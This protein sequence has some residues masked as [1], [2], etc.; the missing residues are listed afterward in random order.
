[1]NDIELI[2]TVLGEAT[3]TKISTDKDSK[4]FV[5]LH[6]DAKTGGAVAG[7]TR[8][9]IEKQTKTKIISRQN[10]LPEKQRKSSD[11]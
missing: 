8:K 6:D 11:P 1:M 10:F 9:D 3:T 7:R 5:N 4:G 2:L